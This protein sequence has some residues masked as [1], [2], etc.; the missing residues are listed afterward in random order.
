MVLRCRTAARTTTPAVPTGPNG[1]VLD[2]PLNT[3][4]Y[5][6]RS[7]G[8]GITECI[9]VGA[10]M[11]HSHI[12]L[13]AAQGECEQNSKYMLGHEEWCAL[14]ALTSSAAGEWSCWQIRSPECQ[15]YQVT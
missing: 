13:L 2:V 8:A 5:L 9:G 12:T 10:C 7:N 3:S 15:M 11:G 14:L 1:W 6:T 4:V